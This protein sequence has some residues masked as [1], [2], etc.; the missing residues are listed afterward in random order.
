MGYHSLN[1]YDNYFTRQLNSRNFDNIDWDN[2]VTE[3]L[4]RIKNSFYRRMNTD[5]LLNNY[6]N[7]AKLKYYQ[8]LKI[9]L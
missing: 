6:K 9:K 7:W 5:N 3:Y 8:K 2:L 4:I 1:K